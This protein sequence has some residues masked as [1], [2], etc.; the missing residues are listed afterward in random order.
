MWSALTWA[1]MES[2]PIVS[3]DAHAVDFLVK[4][5]PQAK[6]TSEKDQKRH[7]R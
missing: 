2:R 6:P 3:Q 1:V 7:F 4:T 5:M